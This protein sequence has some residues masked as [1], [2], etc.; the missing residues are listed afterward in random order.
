MPP[1]RRVVVNVAGPAALL[2]AKSFKLGERLETPER[3]LAKDAGDVYRLFDA[4]AV[5]DMAE[6]TTRLLGDSRSSATTQRALLYLRELFGTP[7]SLGTELATA[8]LAGVVDEASVATVMT[9][10]ARELI[11]LTQP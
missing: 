6:M 8:A 1:H 7:R 10:Y 11:G 5:A 3:L 9:G 2:V 4:T